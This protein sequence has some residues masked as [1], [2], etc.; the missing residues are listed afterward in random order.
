MGY[1]QNDLERDK[2]ELLEEMCRCTNPKMMERMIKDY[3]FLTKVVG[4]G[5]KFDKELDEMFGL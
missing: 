1:N 3:N 5:V 2:Q 4:G